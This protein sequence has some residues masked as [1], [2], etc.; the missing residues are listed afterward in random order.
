VPEFD[1]RP[2][3]FPRSRRRLVSLTVLFCLSW[4]AG[5][6]TVYSVLRKFLNPV[7]GVP[8]VW[9]LTITHYVLAVLLL[10]ALR[11]RWW[12]IALGIVGLFAV[13]LVSLWGAL[14]RS[15]TFIIWLTRGF[16]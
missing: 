1:D 16:V 10:R 7:L 3:S 6:E 11:W 9:L 4:L 5:E 2:P 8:F 14:V 15:L 12:W 13:E